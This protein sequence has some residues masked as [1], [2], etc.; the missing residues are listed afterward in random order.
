MRALRQ[1][2]KRGEGRGVV[3]LE[4]KKKKETQMRK[5]FR[6]A[7][8]QG[9][10]IKERTLS[11]EEK[12]ILQTVREAET[13]RE[14]QEERMKEKEDSPSELEEKIDKLARMI[15]SGNHCVFYTGAGMST[16][17]GVPDYRGPNGLWTR[18]RQSSTKTAEQQ[19]QQQETAGEGEGEE[20]ASLCASPGLGGEG[21]KLRVRKG[22]QKGRGAVGGKNR[23]KE[24]TKGKGEEGAGE[25][26]ES[27]DRPRV[28]AL[29][30]LNENN[31]TGGA[32]SEIP[33]EVLD[34][35]SISP[36]PAH[37][38]VAALVNRGK[39]AHVVSQNIDGLHVRSGV[40]RERLSELH[41][42]AFIEVCTQCEGPCVEELRSFD[43]SSKSAFR[44]H[45]TGR[46]CRECGGALQDS[47]VHFGE[48]G[49]APSVHK[50]G[51]A[52]A[53]A[54]SADLIVCIGTSLRV[55]SRYPVLW[56]KPT[57]LSSKRIKAGPLLAIVNKQWTP[58]DGS[59]SLKVHGSCDAVIC[60]LLEKLYIPLPK[61]DEQKDPLGVR[62]ANRAGLSVFPFSTGRDRGRRG[63]GRGGEEEVQ[64][65]GSAALSEG[66]QQ[67]H[68]NGWMAR[69]AARG[70]GNGG[71]KGGGKRRK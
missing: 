4:E 60:R 10:K 11:A 39:V 70:K 43:V 65:G 30:P 62:P 66:Q 16:S 28:D 68:V 42:N 53:H 34:F 20:G 25:E 17:A 40:P 48:R 15:A 26:T 29:S 6:D 31:H 5:E 36:T 57:R 56:R 61:Y 14:R 49:R 9:K 47:L 3:C 50:W 38:G 23:K 52:A 45:A 59:A 44:R 55:L 8:R 2:P 13:A 32:V 1:R 54:E 19:Q 18:A 64:L 58:K 35:A 22:G 63:K 69:V 33:R 51:E 27:G 46:F 37:M 41:G 21:K 12:K 67:C 24:K 71:Q 7:L